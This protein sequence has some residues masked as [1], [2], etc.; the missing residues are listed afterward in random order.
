MQKFKLQIALP[1]EMLR[2]VVAFRS[3]MTPTKD[4]KLGEK[5]LAIRVEDPW[6]GAQAIAEIPLSKLLVS[7]D[8]RPA[9]SEVARMLREGIGNVN[10]MQ[11]RGSRLYR[12]LRAFR[13]IRRQR[14]EKERTE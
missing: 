1:F 10:K 2:Y 14:R 11:A 12:R 4:G 3:G 8:L 9:V 13:D 5:T 6:T 7:P